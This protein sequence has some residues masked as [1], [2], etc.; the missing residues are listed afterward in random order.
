VWR[1]ACP[2]RTFSPATQQ[3]PAGA[4]LHYLVE[5]CTAGSGDRLGRAVAEIAS[6]FRV[7]WWT[8]QAVV[9]TAA[10]LLPRVEDLQVR[11]LGIDERRYRRVRWFCGP[12]QPPTGAESRRFERRALIT[13]RLTLSNYD[14]SQLH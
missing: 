9:N 14:I 13:S 8:L 5:D 7:A 6:D 3:L 2:R 10:L 11:R 12:S 1:T 4:S